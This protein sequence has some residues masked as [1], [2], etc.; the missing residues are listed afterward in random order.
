MTRKYGKIA[1]AASLIVASGIFARAEGGTRDIEVSSGIVISNA[2]IVDTR[3]GTLTRGQSIVLSDG[4]IRDITDRPVHIGGNAQRVDGTGK[5]VV[6]GFLDMHNHTL[7]AVDQQPTYWPLMIANGITGVREMSGSAAAIQR[8]RQLNADR[9]NGKVDAPEILTIASDIFT[10]QATTA[11]S[12]AQFVEQKLA[13]GADFIK[14]GLGNREA[15]LALLAEAKVKGTYVAGHLVNSVSG[16]ESSNAG[17]HA[18]EH[19]GA[20]F[21]FLLDCSSDEWA[22]REAVEAQIAAQPQF[23]PSYVANPRVFDGV[24]FA[25]L[26]QRTYDTFDETKC[27]TVAR[28]FARNDTWHIPTLIRLR[29]QNFGNDSQYREDP[30][31]IYVDKTRRA[32]WNKLGD[33]YAAL[34]ASVTAS[35]QQFYSIQQRAT[36]LLAIANVKLLTGADNGIWEVPGFSLHQE[37]QELADAG[38]SPLRVL[39]AATLNGAQFLKR[40][41]TMGT[42]AK[43]KNADLVLLDANPLV[44]VRN[45]DRIFAVVLRGK[46]FN[47]ADLEQMKADVAAAYEAQEVQP[48]STVLDPTHAH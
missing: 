45:L 25:P 43:G 1:A 17:W 34:P 40:E 46:L 13:D 10:G 39:Q 15:V 3:R 31:L 28:T 36:K 37:F 48:L 24:A 7:Q 5:Y 27:L 38:L 19:L 47:R 11:A 33:E 23:P 16:V 20:N 18:I 14:V 4:K 9:A 29:T 41:S 12:A 42:V 6:P 26:Y 22:I 32:L 21:G 35:L 30:N 8:A 2:I 44:D